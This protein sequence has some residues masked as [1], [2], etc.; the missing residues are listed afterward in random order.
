V[1]AAK[2]RDSGVREGVF[3]VARRLARSGTLSRPEQT[4]LDDLR[5]WFGKHLK[6][7]ERFTRTRNASHKKIRGI[8]WFKDTAG[9]YL[10]RMRELARILVEN[11]ILVEVIETDRPGYVTYEDEIQLVAE[12]FSDTGA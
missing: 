6:V 4:R 3:Q 7:P 2:H 10:T 8:A 1:V 5:T 12:P 9:D 11:D